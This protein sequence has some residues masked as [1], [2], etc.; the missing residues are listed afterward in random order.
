ML[1]KMPLDMH[2]N[3]GNACYRLE[4]YHSAILDAERGLNVYND[5]VKA[6]GTIASFL[7]S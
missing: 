6:D 2:I 5:K 7:V 4:R 1:Q 3:R